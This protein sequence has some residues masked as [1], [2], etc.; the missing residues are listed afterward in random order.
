MDAAKQKQQLDCSW[1]LQEQCQGRQ[2]T[3]V[4]PATQQQQLKQHKRCAASECQHAVSCCQAA[5]HATC[6]NPVASLSRCCNWLLC[7][8]A[9]P[10]KPQAILRKD[11]TPPPY[12]IDTVHLNFNLN[13]D[14]THVTSKLA[15]KPNYQANGSTPALTLNG[16]PDVKLV[17]VKLAGTAAHQ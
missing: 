14:V 11:Y 13:E 4:L 15:F 16:R 3:F 5:G 2:G 10:A 9:A 8:Q 7:T 1:K 12:M 17:E 6:F